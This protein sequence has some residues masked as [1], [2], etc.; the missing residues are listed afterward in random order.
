LAITN[1]PIRAIIWDMGGVLVRNMVPEPRNRLAE[2]YHLSEVELEKAVFSN[3]VSPRAS[4]GAAGIDELW[5]SVRARLNIPL[6]QLPEFINTFWSSDRMDE[7]L[8]DFILSLKDNFKTAMLSN[9]YDDARHSLGTRFPRLLS[10]FDEVIFS[11]EVK[12]AKPD[13]RIYHL[14]LD[15]LGVKPA[16]A[17]FVDDFI[18]NVEAAQALGITGIHFRNGP[19]ARQ[20]VLEILAS[21]GAE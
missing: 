3:P 9:A 13:P 19:Q 7:E 11:A 15:R 6:Q 17:I 8:V 21:D 2:T 1:Q 18:E 4:V 16:E 14:V 10:A 5:E 12:M 20:A